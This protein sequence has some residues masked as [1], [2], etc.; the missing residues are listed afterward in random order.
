MSRRLPL[1]PLTSKTLSA[2]APPNLKAILVVDKYSQYADDPERFIAEVLGKTLTAQ[3]RAIAQSVRDDRETNVQASHG[4]G[5]TMLAGCLVLWWVLAVEGLCITTAPTAR[6]VKELLWG[7]VRRMHSALDLEG[8]C[9]T[10][11]LRV[12]EDARAYGFTAN[13]NNSNAFQ[14]IHHPKLLVIEDEACGISAEIDEGASSCTTGEQNRFL[15]VGNPIVAGGPFEKSCKRSHIRIAAWDHPNTAWAYELSEDGIH[16]L[17]P[18]VAEAVLDEKRSVKPQSDWP[19]WC[20]RDTIPGAVSVAWIEDVRA[21]YGENSAYWQS[22]VEGLFPE[23][24]SQSVIPRSF[25][26]AARARYDADPEKWDELAKPHAVRFGM[27]IGDGGDPHAL[28]RWQGPVLYG[29]SVHPTQG[30]MQDTNRAAGLAGVQLRSHP[31]SSVTV[32]RGFGSGVIGLLMEQ[33]LN[34]NGVHWGEAASDPSIFLNAKAEDFWKLREALRKEEI[35]IAPLG[36]FEEMLMEDLSGV[37]YEHTSSAKIRMEDKAKTRKRLHRSPDV[38]DAVV[39][40]FRLPPPK[41]Q[42]KRS[43]LKLY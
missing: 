16:R 39:F 38:G 27:D 7:E 17:K 3:Q 8:E 10:V 42:I 31:G 29:A 6:Q 15:R 5:K 23:D 36:E 12:S 20:P 35:A 14:G 9:I 37:Y 40:G 43:G 21:K 2:I 25:F 24:S 41:A 18:E 26:L 19:E 22:R 32:D 13:D 1:P 28:G 33:G 34:A 4:A 30:D 11:A